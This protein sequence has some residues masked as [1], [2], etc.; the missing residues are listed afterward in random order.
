MT[1]DETAYFEDVQNYDRCVQ[2]IFDRFLA[3]PKLESFLVG[4]TLS[5]NEDPGIEEMIIEYK[6]GEGLL[7]K[8]VKSDNRYIIYFT[9]LQK[10]PRGRNPMSPEEVVMKSADLQGL[11]SEKGDKYYSLIDAIWQKHSNK[12]NQKP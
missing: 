3:N 12:R 7:L 8:K 9:N 11:E 2:E 10:C 4:P 5:Q 1:S 6:T